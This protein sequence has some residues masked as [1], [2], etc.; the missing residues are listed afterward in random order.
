MWHCT[1][2]VSDGGGGGG[3]ANVTILLHGQICSTCVSSWSPYSLP[4]I[5]ILHVSPRAMNSHSETNEVCIGWDAGMPPL[6]S[7]FVLFI[8]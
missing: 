5:Y 2:G 3:G 1:E 6:F 4:S 7:A 8:T